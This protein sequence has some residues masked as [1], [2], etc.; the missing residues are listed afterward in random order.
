[1]PTKIK[2]IS[3][4][5][6]ALKFKERYASEGINKKLYGVIS[7]GIYRGLIPAV[8][9]LE[10]TISLSPD[11]VWG[12]HIAI[13]N[14]K[15]GHS[16]TYSSDSGPISLD[17][18]PK[19]GETAVLAIKASYSVGSETS[20]E[21]R[22]YE[23][24][25]FDGLSEE[26]K[27]D[28][29][30]ICTVDVP[31]SGTLSSS[32][33]SHSRRSMAWA[34]LSSE[35]IP[36]TPVVRNGS[37]DI[38][39]EGETYERA[40]PFWRAP[41]QSGATGVIQTRLTSDDSYTGS[42]SVELFVESTGTS[43]SQRI[44][45]NVYSRLIDNSRVRFRFAKRV[46]NPPGS[47]SS[48]F[49]IKF[50]DKD[51]SS[52][53]EISKDI[54][55]SSTDDSFVEISGNEVSPSG[56]AFLE[57]VAVEFDDLGHSEEEPLV[58]VDDIQVWVEAD[59]DSEVLADESIHGEL[60][61][62][63]VI[64]EDDEGA[65]YSA[66]S[67]AIL[68]YDDEGAVS[69]A[70]K[71]KDP[72]SAGPALLTHPSADGD[73]HYSLVWASKP[74]GKGAYR[75]YMTPDGTLVNTL[76]ARWNRSLEVWER[77]EGEF[78]DKPKASRV[79][80]TRDG[81]KFFT[82][83]PSGSNSWEDGDWVNGDFDLSGHTQRGLRKQISMLSVSPHLGD[84]D[85]ESDFTEGGYIDSAFPDR[86]YYI[87][88]D[89]DRGSVI[90]E[91]HLYAWTT[92]Q[93][94]GGNLTIELIRQANGSSETVKTK[95]ESSDG[96]EVTVSATGIDAKGEEGRVHFLKLKVEDANSLNG[97]AFRIFSCEVVYDLTVR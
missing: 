61:S 77:D 48:K 68:E 57:E 75:S 16:V 14:D 34:S 30:V 55:I 96:G 13:Y 46:I 39:D 73:D 47:G 26:D 58:R 91:M 3:E 81:L 19:A 27:R 64:L 86:T 52:S 10:Q 11:P 41:E 97:S 5:D 95:T 51:G 71:D 93:G 15:D 49:V 2:D 78:D 63:S 85:K 38:G 62:S 37:F 25:E 20:A 50:L 40:I 66:G 74:G 79:D 32:D 59:P 9:G 31:S 83:D 92:T 42:R 69:I 60:V 17:L 87:P 89:I 18:S 54:D 82:A 8:S 6:I 94:G 35:A 7:P 67:G 90:K 72:L 65:S 56:S 84:G 29:V 28:N 1:M 23:K 88:L 33:I 12:D 36:W 80:H 21:F 76:N 44:Y 22:L 24:S 43:N 53:G 70:R 45:Q 4:E